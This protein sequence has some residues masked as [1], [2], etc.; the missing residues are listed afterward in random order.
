M[1][2]F[3]KYVLATIV[4]LILTS[5]IFTIITIVSLA[6]MMASEGSTGSVPKNSVLRIKLQGELV[7][8]AG[9]GS[10]MDILNQGEEQSIGLDQALEALKKAAANDKVKG[11]YLEGGSFYATPA[12][13]QELRQGLLE[14]K[15]SGKWVMAYGDSYSRA[16]YY[17]C[18]AADE[19]LLNPS[20]MLDWSG[21]SS[22]PI[23]F[24]GLMK[25]VGVKM[26]VFKVGTY[27][28]AVEPYINTEMSPANR[29]QV[30]SFLGSIWGNMN[31]EVAKSR[32][33]T[34][35]V[36]NALA[37][38]AT[39]LCEAKSYV[40]NKL[41]DKLA[42]LSDV[43]EALKKRLELS[44][45]DDLTFT[46]LADVAAGDDLG[47]KVSEEVAVYYAYGEINDAPSKGFNQE[48]SITT[49]ATITDL[50]KLRK[51]DDVKAVV[52]RVNSPGGSAYASE[53]IWHEI[54]LLR[55]EKPVVVSM[56]GM[57][58]SGGYYISCGANEI[59]AEPTTLTGS[60]GIFGMIPDASEL[61]T[62]KLGLSFD[63][64]KTNTMSDFGAMGRPFNAEESAKMQKYINQGYELFTGRVAGGRGMA[65]DSVKA[66]AEGR[67]WT[68]EQ[69]LKI[70][71]VDKLG[72][73]EDAIKAAAK[74]AE[75]EKYTVGRYPSPEPW[76]IGLIDKSTN[77]YMEGQ[78]RAALGEYYP[79]FALVRRLGKMNPI[80]A[81]LPYDPNIK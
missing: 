40:E 52:I 73:L 45:D 74:L 20:G 7:E 54:Q 49:K 81:R 8:R 47:D 35:E 41:V 16:A 75:V 72:N 3:L 77:E 39:I 69:A 18:S 66:I 5:V 25:K 78:I 27:K 10:P 43:K 28:S 53:Q 46:N 29:E 22:Q 62:Q 36:L 23:F 6:G 70:G 1:K 4:G 79:A 42:Y 38:T 19:V 68:G 58:A 59:W 80:Q 71:L 50:Q 12:M 67:V 26:Q 34:P 51:N 57:A 63:V 24:T 56:G 55:A 32:K 33:L 2:D 30:Q 17:L 44:E 60:I 64:V 48:H 13:L 15:K 65:Q 14:F 37:D 61:L 9:E 21:M 11:I 31:K 76:Y